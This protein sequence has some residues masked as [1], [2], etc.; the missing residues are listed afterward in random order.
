MGCFTP[1]VYCSSWHQVSSITFY[2]RQ[3][4]NPHVRYSGAQQYKLQTGCGV[5]S[6]LQLATGWVSMLVCL[7]RPLVVAHM[8]A[9]ALAPTPQ[10]SIS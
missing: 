6:G 1:K 9:E 10:S 4:S 7:C 3:Q 5:A 8:F 2:T